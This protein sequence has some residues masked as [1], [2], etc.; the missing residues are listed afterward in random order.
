MLAPAK[1]AAR[2]PTNV[3]PIWIVGQEPPGLLDQP[4]DPL[5]AAV[6]LVDELL[7]ARPTDA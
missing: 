3:M 5:G 7:D 4:V 6:A 1:A 2:K